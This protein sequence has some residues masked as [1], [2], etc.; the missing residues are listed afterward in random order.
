MNMKGLDY[1]ALAIAILDEIE[2]SELTL[3]EV[4]RRISKAVIKAALRESHGQISGAGRLL[5]M[6]RATV[7]ARIQKLGIVLGEPIVTRAMKLEAPD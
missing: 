2:Y 6:G 4:E 5:G 3:V 7:I 1:S